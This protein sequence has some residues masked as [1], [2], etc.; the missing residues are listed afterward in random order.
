LKEEAM[1]TEVEDAYSAIAEFLT[2]EEI[3]R[4]VKT[5]TGKDIYAEFC[6]V[7]DPRKVKIK[8]T[9]EA[10]KSSGNERWLLTYV[11]IYV[12]A[13]EIFGEPQERLSKKIVRAF[14]GTLID[15]PK[16]DHHV[17]IIL[18]SLNSVLTIPF[19]PPLK[20][21]LR[22]KQLSFA[23]IVR[24]I[25]TLFAYKS[26]YEGLLLLILTLDYKNISFSSADLQ[27][28]VDQIDMVVAQAPAALQSLGPASAEQRAWLDRLTPLVDSL[29][30]ARSLDD[31]ITQ[32]LQRLV[33]YNLSRLGGLI[34]EA[35]RELSFEPLMSGL[36]DDVEE[37]P[38]FNELVQA[39]RDLTA[40]ILGRV[41]KHRMWQDAEK[42]MTL[43]SNFFVLQV[44][45]PGIAD[46]W[47][48]LRS[49]VEWL[50][51][52]D[53]NE[54]WSADEKTYSEEIQDELCKELAL[55]DSIRG[56]FLDYRN[57]F[58]GP[59]KKVSDALKDDVG[60]LRKIGD[61]ITRILDELAR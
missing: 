14:P 51:R 53:P 9:I 29:R 30:T 6:A 19:P 42:R 3:E 37:R 16:A 20:S 28:I 23:D 15:L 18:E 39:M 55:S 49:R 59:F 26:L 7:S 52:L 32:E 50:A 44:D 47:Y 33:R 8:K 1:A 48:S 31:R 38:G 35:A 34:F 21:E 25:V 45:A 22:P 36:P 12:A 13:H 27:N 5:A 46:D 4:L 24:R 54:S 2:D 40:T 10:L 17:S 56:Y 57:W 43:V 60:S 61:P 41:L 58:V 11:L